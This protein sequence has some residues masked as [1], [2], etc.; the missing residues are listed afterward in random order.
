MSKLEKLKFD[1]TGFHP[2]GSRGSAA[3]FNLLKIVKR[4][5]FPSKQAASA[6]EYNAAT[7][8]FFRRHLH[9]QYTTTNI[10]AVLLL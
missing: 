6:Q 2:I 3:Y 1:S 8:I 5:P 7:I 10:S 9:L 4:I